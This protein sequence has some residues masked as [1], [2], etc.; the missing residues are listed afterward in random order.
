MCNMQCACICL[1]IAIL[2]PHPAGLQDPALL[3]P[4]YM[5][6]LPLATGDIIP[7]FASP[8]FGEI[9]SVEYRY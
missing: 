8:N 1:Q 7:L 4:K 5:E 6:L 2:Q 3:Q 9:V